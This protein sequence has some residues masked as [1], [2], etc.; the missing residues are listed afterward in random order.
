MADSSQQDK[1]AVD[2]ER[3][4]DGTIK[5]GSANP[6]GQPKWV[7]EV[8]DSL[9]ALHPVARDRLEAIITQ[10]EDKDATAAI[11]IVYDFSLPKPKQTHR[12]E[13]DGKDALGGLTPEQLV[14]FVKGQKP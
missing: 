8:R 1:S 12:V 10:G 4:P 7:K 11:R 5:K 6:G 9:R 2:V 3:R 13:S 14:A